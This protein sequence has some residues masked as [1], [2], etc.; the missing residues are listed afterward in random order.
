MTT[1]PTG[2]IRRRA[3]VLTTAI[4]VLAGTAACSLSTGEADEN[5]QVVAAFSPLQ[6]VAE[7]VGGPEV[8]VNTLTADGADPHG[9]ELSPAQVAEL[10]AADLIVYLSGMQAATDEAVQMVEAEH[11]VD[12]A[13]AAAADLGDRAGLHA[14]PDVR[15]DPHFWLDPVRMVL[16]ADDVAVELA[17]RDPDGAEG[18][19]QRAGELEADLLDVDEQYAGALA[20]CAG[21][22]VVTS[23]EAF[24]F[25]AARYG[26]QQVGIAGVDP[27]VEPSPARLR[28][29]SEVVR[30]QDVQTI[31]FEAMASPRVVETLAAELGVGTDVLDPM[32]RGAGADYLEVM[33]ANLRALQDGLGCAA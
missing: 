18:Y 2:S 13:D 12:A 1:E 26:L 14:P 22:T 21:A 25:L 29:V 28:E 6:Y 16:A 19:Q 3:A 30:E 5:L 23:H 32:E 17:A 4:A 11:V 33:D 15:L 24:G 7:R 8:T 20:A 27:E 10:E 9:V 31:Y